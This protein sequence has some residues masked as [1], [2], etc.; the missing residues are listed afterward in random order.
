M[1]SPLS[2]LAGKLVG[3]TLRSADVTLACVSAVLVLRRPSLTP[4]KASLEQC[5]FGLTPG[6]QSTNV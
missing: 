5:R 4:L 6:D 2:K 1:S 3:Q